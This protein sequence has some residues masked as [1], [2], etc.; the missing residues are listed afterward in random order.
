MSTKP[1]TVPRWTFPTSPRG[2]ERMED[3]VEGV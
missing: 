2:G 3:G 1:G